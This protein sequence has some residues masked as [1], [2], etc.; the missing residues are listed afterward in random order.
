MKSSFS[1]A[2]DVLTFG[3]AQYRWDPLKKIADPDGPINKS[4][5]NAD[6]DTRFELPAASIVIVRGKLS[7]TSRKRQK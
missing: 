1:G 4:V 5:V 6:A 2:V 7:E 3:R